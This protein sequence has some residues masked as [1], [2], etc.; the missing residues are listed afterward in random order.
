MLLVSFLLVSG[1]SY[2]LLVIISY[3]LS[4]KDFTCALQ[5]LYCRSDRITVN[6]KALSVIYDAVYSSSCVNLPRVKRRNKTF[7]VDCVYTYRK[8]PKFGIWEAQCISVSVQEAGDRRFSLHFR[9]P[10]T[11]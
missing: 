4:Y 8:G 6:F 11:D 9:L 10:L 1:A 7:V 5:L 2:Y 3:Y